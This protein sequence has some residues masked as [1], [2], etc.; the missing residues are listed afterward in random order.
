M[1][2]AYHEKVS[3]GATLIEGLT[4]LAEALENDEVI[5]ER[6]TFHRVVLDLDPTRYDPPRV[7]IARGILRAS[8]AVLARFLGVSVKT[9]QTWEH[10]TSTPNGMA[11][12]FMGEIRSDPEHWRNRSRKLVVIEGNGPGRMANAK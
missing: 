2:R 5:S 1:G 9:G 4:K 7:K 3:I 10:G 12:A 6:F 8:P 11:C